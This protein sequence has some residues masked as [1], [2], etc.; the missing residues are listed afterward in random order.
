MKWR[1]TGDCEAMICAYLV[2]R[3]HTVWF[4]PV[5]WFL[6]ERG[7]LRS[8]GPAAVRCELYMCAVFHC[9]EKPALFDVF[10]YL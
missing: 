10:G 9:R 1:P 2:Y 3:S 6:M 5:R 4:V 8:V 7:V